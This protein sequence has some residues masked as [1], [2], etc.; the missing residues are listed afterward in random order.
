VL[1]STNQ[2]FLERAIKIVEENIEDSNFDVEKFASE[3]YFSRSQLH[4]KLKTLT[5]YSTT[6]FIRM[7]RLKRA[8]QLLIGNTG[9]ISE[10]AYKVGFD[11][12]GYFSK[13]FK[14]TFG[15]TPS[16]YNK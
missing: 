5:G 10:I 1:K 6:E 8:A 7:I 12:I 11:N 9:T 2:K 4:R 15:K 3:M 13:C 14:E 16:Q